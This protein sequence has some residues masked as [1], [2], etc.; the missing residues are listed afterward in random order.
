MFAFIAFLIFK[1][2]SP[3]KIFINRKDIVETVEK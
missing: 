2:L 1:L 3:K